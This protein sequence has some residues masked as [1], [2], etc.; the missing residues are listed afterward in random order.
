MKKNVIINT[1]NRLLVRNPPIDLSKRF[2]NSLTEFSTY[3]KFPLP[4][5]TAIVPT[6]IDGEIYTSLPMNIWPKLL[7]EEFPNHELIHQNLPE[8]DEYPKIDVSLHD[9]AEPRD[10]IQDDAEEFLLDTENTSAKVL[11]LDTGKGKSFMMLNLICQLKTKFLV[12]VHN[13]SL[14]LNPWMKDA[15]KFSDNINE[16][17]VKMLAGFESIEREL[18]N[19]CSSDGYFISAKTITSLCISSGKNELFQNFMNA[20]NFGL[21]IYEEAH[22][23]YNAIFHCNAQCT[24]YLSVFLTATPERTSPSAQKVLKKILPYSEEWFGLQKKYRNPNYIH[25]VKFNFVSNPSESDI[26]A[27]EGGKGVSI[28]VYSN[29]ICNNDLAYERFYANIYRI[30][31]MSI[32]RDLKLLIYLGSLPL[33][34]KVCDD[35]SEDFGSEYVGNYTSLVKK[36]EKEAELEKL[37]IV[38]TIRSLD[39][40]KD[41]SVDNVAICIP[42]SSSP[43]LKQVYGRMRYDSINHFKKPDGSVRPYFLFDIMDIGF[44][45][46]KANIKYRAKV[47]KPVARKISEKE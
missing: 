43:A 7:E 28:P 41:L 1:G 47:L 5:F 23:S 35:I 37:I 32:E 25:W 22:L 17:N 3:T 6:R 18:K 2:V 12:V 13:P 33:I 38:T 34:K 26:N 40:G 8:L 24:P 30:V 21:V 19:G 20:C 39:A 29:Y 31:K 9:W 4:V 44:P 10:W 45:K 11:A 36:K 27:V 16:D 42:L 46:V 15:N 14:Y